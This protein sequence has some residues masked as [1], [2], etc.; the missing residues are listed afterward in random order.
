MLSN[1][2]QYDDSETSLQQHHEQAQALNLPIILAGYSGSGKDTVSHAAMKMGATPDFNHHF[3]HSRS[4][5]TD[6][7]PRPTE[8]HGVHGHFVTPDQF[9]EHKKQGRFFFDYQ[10]GAYGGTRYGFEKSTLLNELSSKHTFIVGGEIDTS[11]GLKEA[12][13][14]LSAET[15]KKLKNALVQFDDIQL[16]GKS[17]QHV[18][19]PV[20]LFV[21]RSP[22][23][24]IEGIEGRPAPEE[25]KKKRIE[26]VK[27]TWE[28]YPRALQNASE[29][30]E[31]IWNDDLD[32]AAT[33]VIRMIED[34]VGRQ[35]SE[36]YG[37]RVL[38][39]AR[40]QAL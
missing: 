11:L 18:L 10:K 31:L 30:V 20:I 37:S 16:L 40:L 19:Q 12:L 9:D 36:I 38:K 34:E 8:T 1:E 21:N 15:R 24:I 3:F 39:G 13:D 7:P 32:Q 26:H 6:R 35:V 4:R 28:R 17:L 23:K 2:Q 5:Y 22:E 27:N 29:R 14:G 25:E 33:Q